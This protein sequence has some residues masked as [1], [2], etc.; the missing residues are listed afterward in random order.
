M[1]NLKSKCT[2]PASLNR[3]E[4]DWQWNPGTSY[5]DKMLYSYDIFQVS[6]NV[7][8]KTRKSIGRFSYLV[9]MENKVKLTDILKAFVERFH[10]YLVNSENVT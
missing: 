9:N 8:F 3:T 5:L 4:T 6:K 2:V 10:K 7:T 1:L